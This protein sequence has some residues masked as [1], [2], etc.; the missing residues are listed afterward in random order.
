MLRH[1]FVFIILVRFVSFSF[2]QRNLFE[3]LYSVLH[4]MLAIDLNLTYSF[5]FK[6]E[7]LFTCFQLNFQ[8]IS[9]NF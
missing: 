9:T 1:L 2:V 6:I 4:A 3:L 5:N 7:I 8:H